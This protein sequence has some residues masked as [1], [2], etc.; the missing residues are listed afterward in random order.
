MNDTNLTAPCYLCGR[1]TTGRLHRTWFVDAP[2]AED[3]G[4]ALLPGTPVCDDN[5]DPDRRGT[6]CIEQLYSS[7][8]NAAA[9]A[10][11]IAVKHLGY[12]RFAWCPCTSRC[13]V[14]A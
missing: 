6:S 11:K 5:G 3:D 4:Q 2:G 9:I 8:S 12:R 10:E 14:A 13:K 7:T 1:F